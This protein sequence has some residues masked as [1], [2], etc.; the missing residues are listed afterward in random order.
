MSHRPFFALSLPLLLGCVDEPTSFVEV[1][2]TPERSSPYAN[3]M[4]Y[5]GIHAEPGNSDVIPCETAEAFGEVWHALPGQGLTQPNTFS[6]DGSTL[7][8]TSTAPEPD[9]CRLHA[10]DAATGEVLWCQSHPDS[11]TQSA[12]EVDA[13]GHLY[14]TAAGEVISL[15]ADGSARWRTPFLDATGEGDPPWGLHFTPDGHIATV[16]SSGVVA[17][18]DSSDGGLL[19][20]LDIA[21]TWGFV[22]PASIEGSI[23]ISTLLPEAVQSDIAAIWGEGESD[24]SGFGAFLGAGAFCD[25]TLAVSSRGHLYVIGGG[26][27]EDHGA[28]VQIQVGG[29]QE[30]PTLSPGWYTPTN[31]GSATSPS[32]SHGDRYVV[33]SDGSSVA[34]LLAPGTVDARVKVMDID[35]CDDNIDADPD[36]GICGVAYEEALQR[37]AL[38]GSPAIDADGVVTFYEF[39]LDF[40]AAPSDRDLVAFGPDGVLWE[41]AL[42]D[43]RDWTSV[44]TVT[45]HHLIGTMSKVVLSDE[46]ILSLY[47]PTHTEDALAILDRETGALIWET[48]IPDDSA[49]TVTVGPDGALYVGALGLLSMLSIDERPTLGL[50]R[51]SPTQAP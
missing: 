20:S 35:A 25:N 31:A 16:T 32:I 9:G 48:P 17:L 2:C 40:S 45:D 21:Q 37:G 28:L 22:A 30:S 50:T 38:P 39:G 41:A 33:I 11:I 1:P 15:E 26:P 44:V 4:P 14:F 7:Y 36:P 34:S 43:N 19:A 27:D 18:L 29:S 12:V 8:V 5:L 46:Q 42:P 24:G 23:D 49:A 3:G 13:D 51:F 10:L 6:P 47:F